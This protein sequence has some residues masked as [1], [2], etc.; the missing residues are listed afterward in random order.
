MELSRFSYV[1]EIDHGGRETAGTKRSFLLKKIGFRQ[2]AFLP[3]EK[4]NV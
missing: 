2:V 1:R 3:K 4:R